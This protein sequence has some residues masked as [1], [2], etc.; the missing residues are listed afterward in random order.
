MNKIFKVS[1]TVVAILFFCILLKS[2]V[3]VNNIIGVVGLYCS[4]YYF[5]NLNSEEIEEFY[6]KE[7]MTVLIAYNL[8]K[9]GYVLYK[10]VYKNKLFLYTNIIMILAFI[11]LFLWNLYK[12][13]K[14]S[15][16]EIINL[17]YE[18]LI[19]SM[20]F[21]IVKGR[22]KQ[23]LMLLFV[24]ILAKMIHKKEYIFDK[25]LK[26]IYISIFFLILFCII[27]FIGNEITADQIKVSKKFIFNLL[28]FMIF[29]QIKLEPVNLKKVISIGIS[30]SIIRI[31][32]II[33]SFLET[34]NFA[35]R[36]GYENPNGWALEATI[37]SVCLLYLIIFEMR[38]EYTI[39][40]MLSIL[41]VYLSGSRGGILVLI[42]TN[43][44]MLI[45]CYRNYTKK[46]ILIFFVVVS[47]V[48]FILNTNNRIS[49][50]IKLVKYE[51]KIDNSSQIRLIIYKEAFEQFK[52]SPINGIGFNGYRD[53]SIKRHKDELDKMDYVKNNA[54]TQWHTHN[55]FLGILSYTG[56][57]GFISYLSI[58]FF[59]FKK[60]FSDKKYYN[61]LIIFS[62][63]SYELYGIIEHPI[64]FF[65][66]QLFF[67]FIVGIYI[68]QTSN[69]AKLKNI[70]IK[71][72]NSL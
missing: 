1:L 16:K 38:K 53:Y 18:F 58:L 23:A 46:L 10:E 9:M 68:A 40:Y 37:W 2:G 30:T 49:Q 17:G 8:Q 21:Y 44:G 72:A 3:K 12:N 45:Y 27:S 33:I 55:N 71:K 61:I 36:L 64:T 48:F 43:T 34:K 29:C 35:I 57:L 52:T 20:P 5:M 13:K 4:V 51:K 11:G 22:E 31:I 42:L 69:T 19:I 14:F 25:N 26:K 50:S 47:T 66:E 67:Y 15:F 60:L 70:F 56:I 59:L 6:L 62:I 39:L 32:P 7:I 24:I 28:Y 41:G 65:R 63:M 54:Y